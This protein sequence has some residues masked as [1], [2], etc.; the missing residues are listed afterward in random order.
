MR[1]FNSLIPWFVFSVPFL[2]CS[3]SHAQ[4]Q[5]GAQDLSKQKS[6]D[7]ESESAQEHDKANS[8]DTQENLSTEQDNLL[9]QTTDNDMSKWFAFIDGRV[10][11]PYSTEDF[12]VLVN[13]GKAN[14]ST[15]VTKTK[16]ADDWQTAGKVFPDL[17][18]TST[19]PL[20]TENKLTPDKDIYPMRTEM[21]G[22]KTLS[23]NSPVSSDTAAPVSTQTND[24]PN[25]EAGT[26]ASHVNPDPVYEADGNVLS[27][28]FVGAPVKQNLQ[29]GNERI[30]TATKMW[31]ILKAHGTRRIR[32]QY[33]GSRVFSWTGFV[34]A[35]AGVCLIG[36]ASG[37]LFFDSFENRNTALFGVG[38][39]VFLTGILFAI[40]STLLLKKAVR[41][42]NKTGKNRVRRRSVFSPKGFA[43]EYGTVQAGL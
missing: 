22:Q 36:S 14:S 24:L 7:V 23:D 39:G 26:S 9:S 19:I 4:N 42:F 27:L 10:L 29:F 20:E 1:L 15:P 2:F 6:G 5:S 13:S 30:N 40:P 37:M 34:L 25:L 28:D 12:A 43:N 31:T 41:E 3:E 11:G 32:L 21:R 17:F 38:G 16:A 35:V 18:A 33:A 8:P